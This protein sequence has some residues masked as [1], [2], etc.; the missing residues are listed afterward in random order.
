MQSE[1]DHPAQKPSIT[2][3]T[4]R[5]TR[6]AA[7]AKRFGREVVEG[8]SDAAITRLFAVLVEENR[9]N[10]DAERYRRQQEA[11]RERR[12]P[13]YLTAVQVERRFGVSKMTLHRW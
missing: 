11:D 1:I 8:A 13:I 6:V 3:L 5:Q 10:R 7:V 12:A 4:Q 9:A 2:G